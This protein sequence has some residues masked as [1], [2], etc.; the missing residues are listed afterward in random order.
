MPSV[1]HVNVQPYQFP[2][3]FPLTTAHGHW[4]HRAGIIIQLTN[5][6]GQTHRGEIAPLP[7][8]GT[9][10]LAQAAEFCQRLNGLITP[11]QIQ[12]IP[13]RLPCCQFA[14]GSAAWGFAD[15]TFASQSLSY[16]QL[17]PTG[18]AAF[19]YLDNAHTLRCQT[20]KWKI[21]VQGFERE[22]QWFLRLL[23]KL[24][25]Q[26]RLRL[27]ANGGLTLA[28]A[29]QWLTFLDRRRENDHKSIQLEYLEQPLP[30]AQI[31]D[32]FTLAQTFE[33]A[34]ALDEAV[35][36][37]SQLQRLY[38]QQWPG[39][40][41]LKAAIM[42]DPR[43]LHQWLNSHPIPAIFSSVFETAIARQRVLQLAQQW[44]LKNY[45]VGF[46]NSQ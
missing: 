37:F 34:I 38:D 18:E 41:S 23:E 8:F 33:T 2:L 3:A 5:D 25:P 10:D 12:H 26:T 19:D 11:D 1:Y 46:M 4:T 21:G 36:S 20:V 42:G 43:R 29:Q 31:N 45:A 28:D 35:A 22:Q 39:I 15:Q 14:F 30:P 16:C 32:L 17:L 13:D 27:D 9:E 6:R 40:Y 24:P 44:N 7:W